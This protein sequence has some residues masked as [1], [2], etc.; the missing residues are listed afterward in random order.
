MNSLNLIGIV[1]DKPELKTDK[2]TG[3][4]YAK[5]ILIQKMKINDTPTFILCKSA[6]DNLAD[7]VYTNLKRADLIGIEG[8]I[9]SVPTRNFFVNYVEVKTI[10]R[11]SKRELDPDLVLSPEEFANLYSPESV[12]ARQKERKKEYRQEAKQL[13]NERNK[14]QNEKTQSI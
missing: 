10:Y 1:K 14:T 8:E 11:L 2:E 6:N 9:K 5:F 4:V 3:L 7:F 13:E 12:K